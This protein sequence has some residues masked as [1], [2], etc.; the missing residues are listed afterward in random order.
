MCIIESVAQVGPKI[1]PFLKLVNQNLGKSS[2]MLTSASKYEI[3]ASEGSSCEN[4]GSNLS[5][6]SSFEASFH[7]TNSIYSRL[8]EDD[9]DLGGQCQSYHLMLI[10]NLER[11]LLPSS[12][13]NFIYEHT[14]VSVQAY[15]LPSLSMPYARGILVVDS[16]DTRQKILQFLDSLTHLIVS[17]TGS[18]SSDAKTGK[19]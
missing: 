17:S 16:E 8:W 9:K 5:I 11:N 14:S 13:R 6:I 12:F 15:I 4:G 19:L 1:A 7:S 3:S 10:E 2:C 18:F